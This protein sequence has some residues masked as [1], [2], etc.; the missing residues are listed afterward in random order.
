LIDLH[1][2]RIAKLEGLEVACEDQINMLIEKTILLE[3]NKLER[4]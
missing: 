4:Q 1:Q 3:K 2:A